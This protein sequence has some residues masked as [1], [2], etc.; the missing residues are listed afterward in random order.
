MASAPTAVACICWI[1]ATKGRYCVAL[2]TYVSATNPWWPA[3]GTAHASAQSLIKKSPYRSVAGRTV[4]K[5]RRGVQE[6]LYRRK[7]GA[8][9]SHWVSS[10]SLAD[11]RITCPSIYGHPSSTTAQSTHIKT[12][13]AVLM[14][15]LTCF[16]RSGS[17]NRD[18][19]C[20]IPQVVNHSDTFQRCQ[21]RQCLASTEAISPCVVENVERTQWDPSIVL[22]NKA[23]A[24][25]G[26][27]GW[28]G[29]NGKASPKQGAFGSCHRPCDKAW[30]RTASPGNGR[31]PSTDDNCKHF[32][33]KVY[34]STS[35]PALITQPSFAVALLLPP[36]PA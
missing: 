20:R 28:N 26:H 1:F 30:H 11:E 36:R 10:D 9:P 16:G 14:P 6:S 12:R 7:D 5:G 29:M 19:I 32:A 31:F 18:S 27:K 13:G 17:W 33:G 23:V 4:H 2:P 25:L 34:Q 21:M 24:W 15:V 3:R 8:Y 35:L 22:S